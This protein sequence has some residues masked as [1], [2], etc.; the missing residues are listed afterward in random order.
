M[1]PMEITWLGRNCVRIKGR[2]GVVV[3]DPCPPDSG[4]KIGKVEANVVTVSRRDDP[5]YSYREAV[6]GDEVR[7]L[8]APGEYEVGGVLVTG[9]AAKRPD[10]S[11]NVAFIVEMDGIKVGHLGVPGPQL[12]REWLQEF[13][14]DVLLLPVGGVDSIG[15]AMAADVMTRVDPRVAIPVRYR[16]EQETQE[17]D[18]LERFLKETGA[19][20]EP[21][22]KFTVTR[23]Q[24]PAELT[25]VVLQPRN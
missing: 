19:K 9:L 10:G 1:D 3:T 11:R 16:T 23:S 17:L 21:M 13:D 4:F 18:P 2:E 12:E 14:C 8:D 25:V 15:G 6:K 24:L 7:F 20:P 5:G 22:P